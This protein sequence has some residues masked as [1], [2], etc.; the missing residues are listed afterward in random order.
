MSNDGKFKKYGD[1]E[2]S[3]S[4]ILK[5]GTK[6]SIDSLFIE[7]SIFESIFANSLSGHIQLV[8]SNNTLNNLNIMSGD[9]IEVSIKTSAFPESVVN[10][11]VIYKID[12]AIPINEHTISFRLYFTTKDAIENQKLRV[13]K[14]FN[15]N[16]SNI[17]PEILGSFSTDP[18]VSVEESSQIIDYISPN[19]KP[20]D[21][22]RYVTSNAANT[23][24]GN[25]SFTFFET[26]KGGYNL[27]S[28]ETLCSAPHV[29]E[30]NK[31]LTMM[32]DQEDVR[33]HDRL[34]RS[35]DK[36]STGHRI[37]LI[38]GIKNGVYASRYII[39]DIMSKDYKYVDFNR[40]SVT[41]LDEYKNIKPEDEYSYDLPTGVVTVHKNRTDRSSEYKSPYSRKSVVKGLLQ[42]TVNIEVS[43]NSDLSSGD[44]V[45]FG[46]P[47]NSSIMTT[48]SNVDKYLKGRRLIVAIRHTLKKTGYTQVLEIAKDSLSEK[49]T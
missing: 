4:L 29:T 49:L 24:T 44:V 20:F 9:S 27:K 26:L 28:I 34:F 36:F 14:R 2:Y 25:S 11:F 48:S 18:V 3:L 7:M 43:G 5:N 21:A 33:Y 37:D 38:K 12:E 47:V 30:Y 10:T 45:L 42:N 8:D 22:V 19:V 41:T 16:A 46:F 23:D 35:Y 15:G 40:D 31:Y 32:D 39:H 1:V 13:C 17:V 6:Y